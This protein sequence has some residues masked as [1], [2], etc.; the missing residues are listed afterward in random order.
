ML[1][2]HNQ[3]ITWERRK[4]CIGRKGWR[5]RLRQKL[6]IRCKNWA[7]VYLVTNFQ[8][9]VANGGSIDCGGKCHNIKLSMGE[10]NLE[11]PM[12]VIPI[13]G[14]D[15]VLGIQWLRTLGT[16]STNYNELFMRFELEGIQYELKGLKYAP[17]QVINSH[18][19]ENLLKKGSSGVVVR[20]YSME[21][22]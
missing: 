22:K 19:M 20:L 4:G 15:V 17:S 6:R 12:Y 8:V 9:L 16:I 2:S 3:L 5:G 21:V 10:Y 14:V 18:R 7:F 1:P 13:G 11:I